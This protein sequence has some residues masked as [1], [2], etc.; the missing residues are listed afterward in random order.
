MGIC[1]SKPEPHPRKAPTERQVDAVYK[2]TH[3][4]CFYCNRDIAP[5]EHRKGR[6]EVDHVRSVRE[7]GESDLQNYVAACME[8]NRSKG[9]RSLNDFLASKSYK[10]RCMFVLE[11]DGGVYCAETYEDRLDQKYCYKHQPRCSSVYWCCIVR[12]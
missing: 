3:G 12:D 5:R 10:R 8:C 11:D 1:T 7:N 4:R 2:Y 9:K 6:W